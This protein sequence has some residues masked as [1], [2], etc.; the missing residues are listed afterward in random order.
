MAVRVSVV[1]VNF[2]SREFVARAVRAVLA[3]TLP[4]EVIVV[5]NCS[6]DFSLR[7]LRLE[8]GT[9][10]RVRVIRNRCN[11][12]FARACNAGMRVARG[13]LLLF[14]NPDCIVG[15]DAVA[16]MVS[17]MDAYPRAGIAGCTVRNPDGS[18]QAGSRRVVPTPWRSAV[19]VLRLNSIFPN[20][21]RFNSFCQVRA[22]L[23]TQPV[24]AEAISG[25]FM[26][27]RRAA[28]EQVGPL[29]KRYFL[30]CEDLDW[31]LRF[32]QN[33]WQVLFVPDVDVLHYRGA[34][35]ADTPFAVLWHKHK[36]M[37]RFY[38]KFFRH[39]YPLPL[40]AL[41]VPSVW[42]RFGLLAGWE[43]AKRVFR[44]RSKAAR[45]VAGVSTVIQYPQTDRRAG[46]S[47]PNRGPY[48]Y[49]DAGIRISTR[50]SNFQ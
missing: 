23:P 40:M 21:P 34:C 4:V 45:R 13:E 29:D 6:T 44:P 33:G 48:S 14:L 43:L 35:S 28:L 16:R 39:Q 5:D 17:R 1:I 11:L 22:P 27:V 26:L 8:F 37:L 49:T 12:G 30:H 20:H 15:A 36:G 24:F 50:P 38:N 46:A 47:V 18:E 7:R 2:N 25:A 42:I 10:S 31:C 41:V 3:S 9:D 19:R 32:R